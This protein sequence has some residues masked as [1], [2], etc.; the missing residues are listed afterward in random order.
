[1]KSHDVEMY[2]GVNVLHRNKMH[3][4]IGMNNV[5]FTGMDLH[6]SRLVIPGRMLL[7]Y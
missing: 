5:E 4:F 7:N 6:Y 2:E 3:F 1:M